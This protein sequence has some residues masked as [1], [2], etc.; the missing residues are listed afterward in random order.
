VKLVQR[1]FWAQLLFAVSALSV[2]HALIPRMEFAI[3][4]VFLGLVWYMA[5]RRWAGG[6]E[7]MLLFAFTGAAALGLYW[8]APPLLMLLVVVFSLGAWDLDHFTQR[9]HRV[10]RV[11]FDSGL[12]R[13]HLLRLA[14]VEAAG[15][16]LALVPLLIR[17]RLDFWWVVLM[18]LLAVIGLSRVVAFVRRETEG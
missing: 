14:K 3:G 16:A 2:G 17:L 12:G 13:T 8:G 7:N 10:E 4:A 11:E 6:S 5:Q 15:L 1:F 9:L 18:G